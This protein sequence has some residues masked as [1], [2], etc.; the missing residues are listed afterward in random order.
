MLPPGEGTAWDRDIKPLKSGGELGLDKCLN[1]PANLNP[2]V[3]SF[4]GRKHKLLNVRLKPQ[5]PGI[6]V[7]H[8]RDRIPKHFFSYS[9]PNQA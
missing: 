3:M 9:V 1:S 7:W 8:H 4:L 2:H 6:R 5:S